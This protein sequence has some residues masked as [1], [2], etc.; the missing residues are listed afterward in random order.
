MEG[1]MHE[2]SIW[3]VGTTIENRYEIRE[4]RGGGMGIL[5]VVYDHDIQR[6]M[7]VKTP[8][9]EYLSDIRD[10]ELFLHEAK[11][12]LSVKGS[13]RVVTAYFVKYIRGIPCLF[14]EYIEGGNLR[15][16][17]GNLDMMSALH[18]SIQFCYGMLYLHDFMG[19][20]HRDIKPENILITKEGFVKITDF[21]FGDFFW[22]KFIGIKRN[23]DSEAESQYI[24]GTYPYMPPEQWIG[25]HTGKWSDIYS[26]GIVLYEMLTG[27][28]PFFGQSRTE[29]RQLHM[30]ATPVRLSKIIST[31]PTDID[32]L[33][34]SC[35]EKD[36]SR[37]PH[38]FFDIVKVLER[39]YIQITGKEF[40]LSDNKSLS[41]Y[42]KRR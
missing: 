16:L 3:E 9:S 23:Q 18:L 13:D 7:A 1:R 37:R 14:M 5:Y 15:N 4:V 27:H 35:L 21:G 20:V 31:I 36:F 41:I 24:A 26:F 42:K 17:I 11:V 40:S 6:L 33:V 12:M 22:P 30:Q 29:W 32:I 19:I 10:V 2:K 38:D 34:T 39:I 8:R 25:Q 28:L